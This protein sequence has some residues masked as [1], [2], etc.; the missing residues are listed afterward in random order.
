MG[1]TG[2]D[3]CGAWLQM[4]LPLATATAGTRPASLGDWS[5]PEA[6]RRSDV[7]MHLS[8]LQYLRYPNQLVRSY[9]R[10]LAF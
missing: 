3:K 9:L 6:G 8:L 4:T 10:L 2:R 1:K 7:T 5:S